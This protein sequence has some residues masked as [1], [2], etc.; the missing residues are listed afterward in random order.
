MLGGS[1]TFSGGTI[2]TAGTVSVSLTNN[3]GAAGSSLTLNSGTLQITGTN[4]N[5]F[6]G[7]GHPVTFSFGK[8]V[9]L[10]INHANNTF[11]VDTALNQGGG[12]LTKLGVGTLVLN[13]TNKFSGNV[14]I[15]AGTLA[16]VAGGVIVPQ[17]RVLVV[18]ANVVDAKRLSRQRGAHEALPEVL[19]ALEAQHGWAAAVAGA[20]RYV[21]NS[22]LADCGLNKERRQGESR[23]LSA[24]SMLHVSS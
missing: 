23:R 13:Q 7:I 1:N 2:I 15:N 21:T 10:D 16:L 22:L 8:M 9:T 6:S 4:L 18:G 12:G 11:T 20:L 3:L 24:L 17:A 14:A 19:A 5:A